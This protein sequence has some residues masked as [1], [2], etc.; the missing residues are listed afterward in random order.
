MNQLESITFAHPLKKDGFKMREVTVY[1]Y[2]N[3]RVLSFK[4]FREGERQAEPDYICK[5]HIPDLDFVDKRG[6]LMSLLRRVHRERLNSAQ[7]YNFD[8]RLS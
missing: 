6:Y 5:C 2:S 1:V 7:G 3:E 8:F 4:E